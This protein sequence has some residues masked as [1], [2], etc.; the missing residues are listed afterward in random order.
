MGGYSLTICFYTNV[1]FKG[2]LWLLFLHV[3]KMWHTFWYKNALLAFA[4]IFSESK[5]LR[6]LFFSFFMGV[7]VILFITPKVSVDNVTKQSSNLKYKKFA[8]KEH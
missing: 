1:Y 7:I 4:V 5:K 3:N 8:R 2:W 6:N